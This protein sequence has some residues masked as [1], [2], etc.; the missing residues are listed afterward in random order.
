MGGEK[1]LFLFLPPPHVRV[2]HLA[3]N[4]SWTNDGHLH[5]QVIKY[6]RMIAGQRGHLRTALHLEHAYRVCTLQ[7][8]VDQRVLRQLRQV[9]WLIVMLRDQDKRI[10]NELPSCPG[11]VDPL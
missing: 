3:H 4:G 8:F 1:Y 5:Y 10:L 2:H 9:D 6:F 11:P 7:G